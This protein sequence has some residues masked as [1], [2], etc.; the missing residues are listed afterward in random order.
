[1]KVA[2]TEIKNRFAKYID[3]AF[4][5]SVTIERSG[6]EVAVLVSI[7]EFNRLKEIEEKYTDKLSG[8]KTEGS[9]YIGTANNLETSKNTI[10]LKGIISNSQITDKDLEEAKGIWK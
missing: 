8:L 5:E 1:M 3:A 10:S 6:R 4:T 7:A 9:D 2:A